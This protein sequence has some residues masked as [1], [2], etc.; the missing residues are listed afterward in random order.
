MAIAVC[1]V[2]ILAVSII[3][4]T[5]IIRNLLGGEEGGGGGKR[6]KS[7]A[8]KRKIRYLA[9]RMASRAEPSQT[10]RLA[11]SHMTTRTFITNHSDEINVF[12]AIFRKHKADL[13]L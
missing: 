10:R 12:L 13:N 1:D 6:K 9:L 3:L 4:I 2:L 5:Q 8:T 7:H 11:L